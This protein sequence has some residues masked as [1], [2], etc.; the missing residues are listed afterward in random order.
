MVVYQPLMQHQPTAS[1]VCQQCVKAAL[2]RLAFMPRLR[3]AGAGLVR[4]VVF[5]DIPQKMYGSL[6]KVW[7]LMHK[8]TRAHRQSLSTGGSQRI[9]DDVAPDSATW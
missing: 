8:S 2:V 5:N 3:T 4:R 1:V 9:W 6:S 7:F